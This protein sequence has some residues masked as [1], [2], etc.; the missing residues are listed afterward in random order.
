MKLAT[1]VVEDEFKVRE[2]FVDLLKNFCPEIN[3]IAE[4]DNIHTAYTLIIEKKPAVVFLDIEMADGTA[5]DLLKKFENIDFEIVF[6]TS[7]SHYALKAIKLSALDYLLKPVTIEELQEVT[8]K[9]TKQIGINKYI[10]QYSLLKGNLNKSEAEATI[11]IVTKNK[12]EYVPVAD[13]S[14]LKGDRNY[15][16][17]YLK[18]GLSY[19]AA[20][21]LKEY[22]DILCEQSLLFFRVHKSY[23]VNVSEI[24]HI[25]RGENYKIV[26]RDGNTLEVSRRKR[27]E[28]I[29]RLQL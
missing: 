1:I 13:I 14:Y 6:V 25:E 19:F 24:K 21:T 15:S 27:Q 20:R 28:L 26:L 10:Q 23:I 2:V 17:V 22:E 9:I 16:F 8:K 7:Y 29:E 18:N 11:A 5:F 12:L 3:V 4:A